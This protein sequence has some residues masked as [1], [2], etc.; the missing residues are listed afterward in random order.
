MEK[1]PL[2][3]RKK[4]IRRLSFRVTFG[5]GQRVRACFVIAKSRQ[6]AIAYA[7]RKLRNADPVVEVVSYEHGSDDVLQLKFEPKGR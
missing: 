7:R 4:R 1:K 6:D 5:A 2:K 3:I